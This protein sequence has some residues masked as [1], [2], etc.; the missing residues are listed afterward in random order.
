MK[1]I[2]I[3]CGTGIATSTVV[4]ERVK[5]LLQENGLE[6]NIIQCTMGDVAGYADQ[7]DVIITTM[8]LENTFS[9][10]VITAVSFLTGVGQEETEQ[11]ILQHLQ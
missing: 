9:K 10:P 11:Q 7:A 5:A 1:T 2:V 4:V 8:Q 6:A 3:A